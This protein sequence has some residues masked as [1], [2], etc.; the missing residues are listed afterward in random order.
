MEV[1]WKL[2]CILL[3][4]STVAS[5]P[6][7]GNFF[8][9]YIFMQL[10]DHQNVKT[11]RIYIGKSIFGEFKYWVFPENMLKTLNLFK[12]FNKSKVFFFELFL[13]FFFLENLI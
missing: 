1:A 2:Y 11:E 7:K 9:F 8:I 5:E 3:Y 13:F 12:Y 10:R 6:E 4:R